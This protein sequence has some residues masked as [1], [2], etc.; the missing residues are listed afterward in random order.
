MPT[1][2]SREQAKRLHHLRKMDQRALQ[3]ASEGTLQQAIQAIMAVGSRRL[4]H[5]CTI[6]S[7][8]RTT[9]FGGGGGGGSDV[10]RK[11]SRVSDGQDGRRAFRDSKTC[12]GVVGPQKPRRAL[13]ARRKAHRA[14]SAREDISTFRLPAVTTVRK[15][16]QT[17]LGYAL[18]SR[19]GASRQHT[20]A[21]R[22]CSRNA[23]EE[24]TQDTV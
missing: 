23:S 22:R 11:Y 24:P 9:S 19:C 8:F 14:S 2:V 15:I 5:G 17:R 1:Q 4:S 6:T 20:H 3:L 21:I 13:G 12:R 18:L 16:Q 10:Y 7:V